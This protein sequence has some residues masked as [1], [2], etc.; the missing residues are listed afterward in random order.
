MKD[1]MAEFAKNAQE[2]K[3]SEA[4][5]NAKGDE[6]ADEA[7]DKLIKLA[8]KKAKD[9]DMEFGD[10]MSLTLSE[11]PDLKKKAGY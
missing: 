10:A 1:D 5:S 9:D 11:N 8:E 3:L 6:S 4:G 2:V 7:A